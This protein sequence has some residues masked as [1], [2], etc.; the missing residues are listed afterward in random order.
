MYNNWTIYVDTEDLGRLHFSYEDW[1][2][3]LTLLINATIYQVWI[4][5]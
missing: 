4:V 3:C 2:T 1:E 5:E